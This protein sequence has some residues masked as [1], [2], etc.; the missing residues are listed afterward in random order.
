MHRAP[1]YE[2]VQRAR[3]SLKMGLFSLGGALWDDLEI[4]RTKA[5]TTWRFVSLATALRDIRNRHWWLKLGDATQSHVM[6]VDVNVLRSIR[7]LR[8][9]YERRHSHADILVELR[10]LAELV[11]DEAV[12]QTLCTLWHLV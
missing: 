5:I 11:P 7:K 12:E 4:C 8:K 6:R 3:L 2:Q 1:T 9:K 10:E